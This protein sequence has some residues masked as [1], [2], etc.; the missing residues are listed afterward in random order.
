MDSIYLPW[1]HCILIMGLDQSGHIVTVCHI[2]AGKRRIHYL[3]RSERDMM[4]SGGTAMLVP[5][6]QE[7]SATLR[8]VK[9]QE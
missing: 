1:V 6:V 5:G 3:G 2:H 4:S 8:S 7:S 9:A